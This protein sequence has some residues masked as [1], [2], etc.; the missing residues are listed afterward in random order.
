MKC[1]V[2]IP[3]EEVVNDVLVLVLALEEGEEVE[4][5]EEEAVATKDV[6]ISDED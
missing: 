4:K 2:N 5:E 3:L 1:L 6:E